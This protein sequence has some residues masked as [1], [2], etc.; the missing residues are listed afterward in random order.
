MLKDL[1]SNR[2]PIHTRDIRLATF[3]HK[4]NTII[5]EGILHD[6]RAIDIF[7]ITG[8]IKPAGTVHHMGLWLMI[9]S[10]PLTIIDAQADMMTVPLDACRQTLDTVEPVI[11]LEIRSGFTQQVKSIMGG[12]K[13]CTHLCH[14]L[15]VMS[16]EI[17]HGVLTHKRREP[18]G[19]P[20][21]F[22]AIEN[23]EFLI[24]SCRMWTADGPKIKSIESAL[25]ARRIVK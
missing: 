2:A 20:A 17:V 3:P 11:G 5:V 10:D 18:V 12:N 21:S 19:I 22:D 6:Q 15:T 1:I 24:D 23:S 8:E 9:R 13:G 25:A 7:D 16:Q 4:D 14:L